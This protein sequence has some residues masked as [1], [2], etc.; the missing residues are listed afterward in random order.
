M[1]EIKEVP[2]DDKNI[3]VSAVE[4]SCDDNVDQRVPM[5]LPQ[6]LS[7]FMVLVGRPGSGKSTL[8]HTLTTILWPLYR[9]IRDMKI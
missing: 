2:Y 8:L 9:T 4:M 5:P 1:S 3:N 7:F 6:N